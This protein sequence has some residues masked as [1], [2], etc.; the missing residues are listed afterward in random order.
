MGKITLH[1]NDTIVFIGDSIT[2]NNRRNLAYSPFGNG[3]VHFA[4]NWLLGRYP[5]FKLNIFNTGIS[6]DT[7]RNLKSRWENDCLDLKPD[8]L[9]IL[10]NDCW[11]CHEPGCMADAV[12]PDEYEDTYYRLISDVRGRLNC[13][14]VLMEP[15]MFC[16]DANNSM[17]KDLQSYIAVVHKLAANFKAVIVPLQSS[18]NQALQGTSP[19]KWSPDMVHPQTW[20]SAWLAQRWLETVKVRRKVLKF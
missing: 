6:G 10:I 18:I 1:S 15:F 8:V 20:A 9:S 19:E 14:L 11:R 5:E 13:Q 3:Y 16:A 17:F 4:A 7:I 2:D 12:R